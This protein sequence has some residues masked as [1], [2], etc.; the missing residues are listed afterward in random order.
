MNTL[1]RAAITKYYKPGGFNNRNVFSHSF[2]G[3]K[4]EIRTGLVP[5]VRGGPV[6]G[7]SPW[8]A[9]GRLLPVCLH[10]VFRLCTSTF[11]PKFPI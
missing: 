10:M 9:D 2:G 11:V 6:A 1:A 5:P 8:T 7:H 4:S 3:W